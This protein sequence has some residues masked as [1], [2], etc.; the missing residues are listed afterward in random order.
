MPYYLVLQ[1]EYRSNH[2]P[3]RIL[4]PNIYTE[5]TDNY[6]YEENELTD[7]ELKVKQIVSKLGIFDRTIIEIYADCNSLRKLGD[8]LGVSHTAIKKDV[9]RIKEYVK[10]EYEKVK[11]L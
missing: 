10:K 11:E 1:N 6:Q 4:F 5:L 7:K 9:D 2:S 3:Y 8:V